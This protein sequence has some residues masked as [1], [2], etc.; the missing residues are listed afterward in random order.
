MMTSLSEEVQYAE[1]Y[2]YLQKQRYQDRLDYHISME[3]G[4][5][6][7]RIPRL[8]IEP[9]VENSVLHGME[10]DI[11]RVCVELAITKEEKCLKIRIADNGRGFDTK[12]LDLSGGEVSLEGTREKVGLKNT[13]NRLTLLY[14]EAYGPVSYTHLDVYKRQ[15]RAW[16]PQPTVILSFVYSRRGRKRGM[17]NISFSRKMV[18]WYPLPSNPR[19]FSM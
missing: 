10:G 7:V 2:L 8:T 12:Q 19:K 4:L 14:G 3:P 13:H 17:P 1:F 16:P 11:E 9:I 18:S 5:E 6:R 15:T